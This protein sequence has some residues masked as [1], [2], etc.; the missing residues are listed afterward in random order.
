MIEV[1]GLV[2][3]F[4]SGSK[5]VIAL[6]DI[7]L[8]IKEGEFTL[9]KGPS[10]CGK[11]TL[12]FCMGGLLKPSAGAV[13]I[14]GKELYSIPEKERLMYRVKKTGMV[15]QSYYLLP[16][17][18]V[19]EN[20]RISRQLDGV[21]FSD[22]EF[23]KIVKRLKIDHRL[24]HKPSELSVGE[25]QRVSLAR[26]LILKPEVILADEPTGN[27]DPDNVIV[28]LQCLKEFKNEG[29]TV[30]MVTHGT[31]ADSFATRQIEMNNGRIV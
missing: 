14:S 26:A 17:F 18:T 8:H 23:F 31:E 24:N 22:D 16:Y 1:K 9:I 29:G 15:Y 13:L 30:V 27:L 7:D 10:G 21:A 3:R 4:N 28:V 20:I 19:A 2:K 5:S 12:L 11:S 6:H 25:K